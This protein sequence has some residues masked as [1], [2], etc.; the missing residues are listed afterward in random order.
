MGID[1]RAARLVV[2]ERINRSVHRL[3]SIPNAGMLLR[4]TSV[5]RNSLSTQF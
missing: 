2:R 1:T 4:I 3:F 5:T